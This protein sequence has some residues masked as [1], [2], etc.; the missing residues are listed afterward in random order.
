MPNPIKELEMK[1][2]CV[3]NSDSCG[4]AG[5]SRELRI[6]D[7]P[8]ASRVNARSRFASMNPEPARHL[9]PREALEM[10][11]ALVEQ[12]GAPDRISI[13]GPGDP[14]AF[15]EPTLEALALIHE[16]FPEIPLAVKTIGIGGENYADRLSKT[17]VTRVDL[18][19]NAV[20]ED[21]LERLYAWIRPGFKTI[22]LPDAAK[23]LIA[24]QK[25]AVR[26]F[27]DAGM[28]V[29]VVTTVYPENNTDH[30]ESI[31]RLMADLGA[32]DMVLVP[33]RPEEGAEI[34]LRPPDAGLMETVRGR[35]SR[36]ITISTEEGSAMPAGALEAATL[37]LPKPT[38]DRPN[39]AVVSSNGMDI[40]LHLG[41]AVQVLI[42]GPREDGLACLLGK[43]PAPEPGGEGSRW[44]A[45]A[46]T[47]PDC[48][49]LLAASAGENPRKILGGR[50]I[51]V[52]VTE[53]TVDGTV[54][55]LYGGGRKNKKG[56]T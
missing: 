28:T 52:L 34:S 17:G 27:K 16:R 15:I 3:K 36:F 19:V 23:I 31:A 22:R 25:K 47:L 48:F 2:P 20:A 55:V 13:S 26:A 35:A 33:F 38:R 21:V 42:Y 49:A 32:D 45:L 6:V 51:K 56:R 37:G 5:V 12:E 18:Q 50:G 43:R 14:L 30:I 10:V 41:E 40:D 9:A 46:D 8:A 39:V 29:T 4:C 44:E 11:T 54:D 53:D 7:L 24:E 1:A